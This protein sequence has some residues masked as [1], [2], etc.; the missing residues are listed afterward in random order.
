MFLV[1]QLDLLQNVFTHFSKTRASLLPTTQNQTVLVIPCAN[2]VQWLSQCL[3]THENSELAVMPFTH[4]LPVTVQRHVG[5]EA[6]SGNGV[7][8]A[9]IH[10]ES[11]THTHSHTSSHRFIL[12]LCGDAETHCAA[13]Y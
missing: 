8:D 13:V 4:S 2:T 12:E 7:C 11:Q 1:K 5:S 10:T 3:H 9:G 6:C